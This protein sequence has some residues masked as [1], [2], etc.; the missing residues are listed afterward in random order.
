MTQHLNIECPS[1]SP[2]EKV[3]HELIKFGINP[4]VHCLECG[5]VYIASGLKTP[6]KISVRVYVNRIDRPFTRWV[7]LNAGELLSED[8][9]IVLDSGRSSDRNQYVITSLQVGVRRVP[10]ALAEEL[11]TIWARPLDEITFAKR[12]KVRQKHPAALE[13][14]I[15]VPS[16][17]GAFDIAQ[18]T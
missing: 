6:D 14:M 2:K 18:E 17:S 4:M 8:E 3:S 12:R 1:C 5:L 16:P 9:E 11:D 10:S 13:N 15:G 7:K